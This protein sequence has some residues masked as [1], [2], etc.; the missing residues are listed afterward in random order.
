LVPIFCQTPLCAPLLSAYEGFVLP[1]RFT[2]ICHFSC[3][4]RHLKFMSMCGWI[5]KSTSRFSYVND[6]EAMKKDQALCEG[7]NY[8]L[9]GCFSGCF[10]PYIMCLHKNPARHSGAW[11]YP[12]N[13]CQ[14]VP[15][16]RFA[17]GIRLDG[18]QA[19]GKKC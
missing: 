7:T 1:L 17:F 9:A 8:V 11:K 15:A 12:G 10:W 3:C 2:L 16:R 6:G 18:W 13:N 19:P 5:I 4:A 14:Q